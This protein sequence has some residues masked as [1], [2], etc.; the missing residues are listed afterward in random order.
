MIIKN[1]YVIID[2]KLCKKDI[3]IKG[4]IIADIKD[5]INGEDV[6]DATDC[7]I[8][9]GAIDVHVHLREPGFE[10]KETIKT[11]TLAAAKGGVTE[12]F[13]MPN[14]R[15]CPHNLENLNVQLEIIKKDAVVH[16]HPTGAVSKDEKGQE[17]SSLEE[18]KN[19][20]V[21]FT[22]DGVGVNN[23]DILVNAMKFAKE[24]NMVILSHAEDSVDGKLPKGEYEAVRREI[25]L[26]KEIG[27]RYH[28]MHMSTKESF[29]EIR[30]AHKQGYNNITCEV[31]PHHLLLNQDD[32]KNGNYK[33]NPPLRSKEDMNETIKA[34]LDNTATIIASDHAPHALHEKNKEYNQCLNGITGIEVMLPL[35]YTNFIETKLATL[36][37]FVDWFVNNPIKT[38]NLK[39]RKVEVGYVADLAILDI[40]NKRKYSEEEIV[41]L[42]K[43]TPYIGMELLGFPRFTLIDGKIVWRDKHE[44]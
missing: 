7:L 3:E 28:F 21:A 27:C 5:E 9:P 13:S 41:S 19:H 35:I 1:G 39:E 12:V 42:S 44:M 4:N 25:A 24:N 40:K 29:E 32:I 33:M 37:D 20:V 14:L 18:I 38:F 26:A 43:N 16:V 11:G 10:Y 17:I 22:D 36:N 2:N 23:I 34:L 31:A 6:I 30:L 15:P 8:M